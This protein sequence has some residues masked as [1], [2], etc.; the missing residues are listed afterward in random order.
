MKNT[1]FKIQGNDFH[2]LCLF[3]YLIYLNE[4]APTL[5]SRGATIGVGWFLSH[6][7]FLTE[8]LKLLNQSPAKNLK[9][10]LGLFQLSNKSVERSRSLLTRSFRTAFFAIVF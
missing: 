1:N 5:A 4:L 9:S 2:V 8:V 3:D 7:I 10:F 6:S